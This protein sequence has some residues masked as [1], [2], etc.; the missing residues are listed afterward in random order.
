M[1][2]CSA[3]GF[4]MFMDIAVNLCQKSSR[5]TRILVV[6]CCVQ[7]SVFTIA[8]WRYRYTLCVITDSSTHA[9]CFFK[10]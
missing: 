7:L 5:W 3:E 8:I 2:L 9:D 10:L 1:V 6:E 4:E